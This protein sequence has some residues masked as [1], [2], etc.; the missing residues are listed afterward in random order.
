M[1]YDSLYTSIEKVKK[2]GHN[3][4]I[5]LC[6]FH[7][8]TKPSFSFNTDSGLYKCHSC[9]EQGNAYQLAVHLR[10]PKP[11]QYIKNNGSYQPLHQV[12]SSD[13][14]E[15]PKIPQENLIEKLNKFKSNLKNKS[16]MIP[17]F[18]NYPIWDSKLFDVCGLGLD[19]NDNWAF[20]YYDKGELIG[21]K[22][23]K[24]CRW[25]GNGKCKW[26]LVDMIAKYD[27]NKPL[28]ICEGEKDTIS[29]LTIGKQAVCGSAGCNSIPKDLDWLKDWNA[30]IYICYDNDDAGLIGSDKIGNQIKNLHPHLTIIIVNWDEWDEKLAVG[31]DITDSMENYYILDRICD[32]GKEVK[33]SNK[34][35]GMKMIT[36]FDAMS[37][38]VI[39]RKQIIENLLPEKSQVILGGTTGA[40]KSFMAM[41]MG[42]SI[43]TDEKEF[44]GFKINVNGLKVLYCDTECGEQTLVERFQSLATHFNWESNQRF[45]LLTKGSTTSDIYDDLESAVK[46]VKPDVVIVDCLYNTTNGADI[47]KNHNLTPTLNRITK[48]KEEFDVTMLVIHHFNK[49]NHEQGLLIDRVAGGS[50]LINWSEHINLLCK[51]EASD[52]TRLLK[53]GKSR[54][55]HYPNVYF[56]L[57]WD[58]ESKKLSNIGIIEDWK[59]HLVNKHKKKNWDMILRDLADEFSTNDFINVVCKRNVTERTAKNWLRQMNHCNIVEKVKH[60]LY[61]KK[62]AIIGADDEQ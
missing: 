7:D 1:D 49:G 36:G 35:G 20:G 54:H 11:H 38:K 34:I 4:F 50:A 33:L 45:N 27:R 55:I 62:L 12:A 57:E 15:K 43:A 8:D 41:Q 47:S 29:A 39:P 25:I 6:P 16:H 44:L 5:G 37:M 13:L 10:L 17:T 61:R 22:I 3:Q 56:G 30:T 21:I 32:K 23:H 2:T 58:I 48:I 53:I 9:G 14:D 42:M 59:P 52:T 18:N 28:Y 60:G 46:R 31:Y 40:N 24:P 26:Y 51:S 19:D